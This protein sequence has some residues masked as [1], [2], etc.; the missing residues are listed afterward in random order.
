MLFL[1]LKFEDT[2]IYIASDL[3]RFIRRLEHFENRK[4][5]VFIVDKETGVIGIL[6]NL[7]F[8]SVY[9]NSANS[10]VVSYGVGK[11]FNHSDKEQG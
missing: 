8:K 5:K 7:P 4:Q 11:Y 1:C 6:A 10:R 2:P 3:S 9:L